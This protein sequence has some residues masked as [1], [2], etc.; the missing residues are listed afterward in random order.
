VRQRI[1]LRLA[2]LG[3]ERHRWVLG[4]AA[5][6]ALATV[7]LFVYRPPRIQSD[8]LDLLPSDQ[9]AVQ[10]FRTAT[11]D[12][13]SLDYLFVLMKTDD[14]V[15]HPIQSYE[16]VADLL[17]QGLRRSP[18]IDGVDYRLQDYQ[19]ILQEMLPRI[20]LYLPPDA[21]PEVEERLSDAGIRAQ[22]GKNRELLT[23]PASFLTKH[24]I[25]YDPFGLLPVFQKRFAGK[26]TNMEVDASDGYYASKDGSALVLIVRPKKPA[27]DVR[28]CAALMAE[29]R[30][31]VAE[32]RATA[33]REGAGEDLAHLGISFGG[34]YPIAQSDFRLIMRDA[35]LNTASSLGLVLF[36]YLWAFRR[37]SSLAYGWVPLL[38]GILL[39][40]GMVHL[41]GVTINSATA[42]F[43]ALLI[44]M[45]IDFPT[46]L[47]GRYIEE[48]NR[49]AGAREAIASAM[50]NTGPGVW[51]GALTTAT[52]FGA[53][54]LTRFP[55]MRQVG[56][57]TSCGILLCA[58][59]VF[60]LLPAML[61]A[62]HLRP[63]SRTGGGALPM[64]VF[65]IQALGD[66]AHRHPEVTLALSA[67][68]TVGLLAA[69]ARIKMDDDVQ[70]LRSK[71]NEGIEVS[72]E[73]AKTF[74]ASLTYMMALVEG[75]SP[76]EV[77]SK[78]ARVVEAVDPFLK[79]EEILYA[80]SLST[81][82][83]PE[84]RQREVMERLR[85]GTS[86]G[87]SKERI[88]RTFTEAC[89][90]EGFE[91]AYFASTLDALPRLLSPENPV[92]YAELK[93]GPAGPLLSKY[94]VEK[95][96]GH[97]RGVVYLY[98]PEGAGGLDPDRL[99]EVVTRAVPGARVAGIN[100]LGKILREMVQRDAVMAFLLGLVLVLIII[101][102]DFR[103][104]S[105]SLY[106]LLPL[107]LGMVWMVGTMS[108]LGMRLNIMNVF[109]TTMIIGIGS[110][111][112]IYFVHR[113]R[114]GDGHD[115]PRVIRET[116]KPIAIAALTTIAGFGSMSLSS[117]PGL[118]SMGYVSL[119][120]TLYCMVATLTALVALLTLSDRRRRRG[121]AEDIP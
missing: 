9:P 6:L 22:V 44:G 68:L 50:G 31:A 35:V 29:A 63:E 84:S 37:R 119:L 88:R 40:F 64:N 97:F 4:T 3:T 59:S 93:A 104:V 77:V 67:I 15:N 74:G 121:M 112:G 69:A 111:Y 115:M 51:V 103:S 48:R 11:Q 47:Y 5:I 91:P 32:A 18:R 17:A 42:G 78:S 52:T 73:V 114:E 106:S 80:D 10:E 57:L 54:L 2:Q 8:I 116:G 107:A 41:L 12:F 94:L 60:F 13:K 102:L 100:R 28:F 90:A 39:T 71:S 110:D 36:I 33:A 20:L 96:P 56:I 113:H 27:Q 23:N 46:V 38:F 16:E 118:R 92:T 21:I 70:N 62:T 43:G 87:L 55:G 117:Y 79:R 53:M 98:I 66:F 81:Y 30:A 49:G 85:A 108:L 120:G 19:G 105:A 7:L 34:G 89:L 25:R 45:G 75:S 61:Q 26:A 76:D 65:R 82:L 24:L 72:M 109:V 83:P 1:L 95:S 14:P 58:A 86:A 99:V 101:A